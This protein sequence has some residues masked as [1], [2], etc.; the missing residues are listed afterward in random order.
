MDSFYGMFV[1]SVARGRNVA[2]TQVREGF[3]QGRM[4]LA[5]D[6]V[7]QHMADRVA[8]FDQ[9]I[10]RLGAGGTQG[11]IAAQ[12]SGQSM[13]IEERRRQLD[14]IDSL[15]KR[16]DEIDSVSRT[17]GGLKDIERRRRE[18]DERYGA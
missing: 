1:K 15:H 10:A 11:M 6:A 4:V 18:L 7:K 13:S 2:Q 8:T 5:D 14:A 12:A 17:D 3:G 9:T 16:R